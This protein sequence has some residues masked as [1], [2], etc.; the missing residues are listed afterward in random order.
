MGPPPPHPCSRPELAAT[1][2]HLAGTICDQ[3]RIYSRKPIQWTQQVH[4]CKLP[5]ARKLPCVNGELG[6]LRGVGPPQRGLGPT[7]GRGGAHPI[8][9][10]GDDM[11]KKTLLPPQFRAVS[12][13]DRRCGSFWLQRRHSE[14]PS[15][16]SCRPPPAHRQRHPHGK[17]YRR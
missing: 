10:R 12:F 7:G 11:T 14:G 17:P 2:A 15:T 16:V 4:A 8:L 5:S 6:L 13:T 3:L 9:R 1:S